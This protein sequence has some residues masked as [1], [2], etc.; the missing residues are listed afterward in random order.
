ME[1]MSGQPS[2]LEHET[3]E[4]LRAVQLAY[5]RALENYGPNDSLT[6]DLQ[7]LIA[8][9]VNAHTVEYGRRIKRDLE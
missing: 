1:V 8:P 9:L 4:A 6:R 3:L 2:H 7:S 5:R